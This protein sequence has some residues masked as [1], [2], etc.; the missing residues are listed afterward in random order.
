MCGPLVITAR[1]LLAMLPMLAVASALL[2][3]AP[4]SALSH[5]E[6][7]MAFVRFIEWPASSMGA[8]KTLVICQPLDAPAHDLQGK[9]VRGLTLHVLH[10]SKPRELDQCHVFSALSQREADWAPWLTGLK[11]QP[12]LTVGLGARYCEVGGAICLIKDE[13]AG[14]EKYQLNLDSLSRGGFKVRSQLLR[15]QRPRAAIDG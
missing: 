6:W 13:A 3:C 4:V 2:M 5:D 7:V 9:Q 1:T 8:N 10:I 11:S 15:Q 12:I 14:I